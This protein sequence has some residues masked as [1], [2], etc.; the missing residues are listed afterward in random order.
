MRAIESIEVETAAPN[1][2]ILSTIR[3]ALQALHDSI[4]GPAPTDPHPRTVR[5]FIVARSGSA[6]HTPEEL[7]LHDVPPDGIT[8]LDL[9][10]IMAGAKR[11]L[12][13]SSIAHKQFLAALPPAWYALK[14]AWPDFLLVSGSGHV[15]AV[16]VKKSRGRSL[17]ALQLS[18]LR[19]LA[20]HG[21]PAF[22]WSPTTG[23][24]RIGIQNPNETL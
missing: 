24:D 9:S 4:P 20:R 17:K 1:A 12:P 14:Q 2:T 10:R 11:T 18:V 8:P 16:E 15:A 19:T 23:Y 21:I 22:R 13:G 7:S 6:L 3:E 5:L